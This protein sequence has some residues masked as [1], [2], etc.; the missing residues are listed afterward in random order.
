MSEGLSREAEAII[1]AGLLAA[2]QSQDP[3]SAAEVAKHA[4]ADEVGRLCVDYAGESKRP[5]IDALI[6]VAQMYVVA[7]AI[8]RSA[9]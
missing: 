8:E 9:A 4:V 6:E 2:S 5:V 1:A 7:K 3:S